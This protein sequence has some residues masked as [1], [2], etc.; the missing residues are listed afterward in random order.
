MSWV[1]EF[2]DEFLVFGLG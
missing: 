2:G 1:V